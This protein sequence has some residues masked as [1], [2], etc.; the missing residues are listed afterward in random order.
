MAIPKL[1][2]KVLKKSPKEEIEALI[3]AEGMKVDSLVLVSNV[4][5]VESLVML[6]K[7]TTIGLMKNSP[8]I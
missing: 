6:C 8:G 2:I 1:I 7:P 4:N 3:V 5:C